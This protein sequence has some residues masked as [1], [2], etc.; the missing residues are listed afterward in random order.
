MKLKTLTHASPLLPTAVQMSIED[1]GSTF[2]GETCRVTFGAKNFAN[3]F[4]A[5]NGQNGGTFIPDG[6][7]PTSA[8]MGTVANAHV[9]GMRRGGKW[10]I[11]GQVVAPMNLV[12]E[13]N[14]VTGQ[15]TGAMVWRDGFSNLVS[16]RFIRIWPPSSGVRAYGCKPE[17]GRTWALGGTW[18]PTPCT[19]LDAELDLHA[20]WPGLSHHGL[21]GC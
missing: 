21:H 16:A 12:P 7:H 8:S 13:T 14:R 17:G 4:Y 19:A 2:A 11:M 18:M 20:P 9:Y 1:N 15:L 3:Y 6:Q 10:T 5:S